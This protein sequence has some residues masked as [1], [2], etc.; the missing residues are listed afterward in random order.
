MRVLLAAAVATALTA[1]GPSVV[2]QPQR[3]PIDFP[4]TD[5]LLGSCLQLTPHTVA[6]T[7]EKVQLDLRIVLDGASRTEAVAAVAGM[8]RAYAPLGV[9]V[10]A[11]YDAV[12]LAGRD[13]GGLLAQAKQLY[14]GRRPADADVVYVLTDK[15]IVNGAA[16]GGQLAGL[17]DCIGGIR[18]AR[19]AF[20]VGELG[21]VSAPGVPQGTAKTMAHEVGHLLGAQHHYTGPEGRLDGDVTTPL[22]L[23]GPAVQLIAL[24]FSQLEA[25]MVRG[26][27]QKYA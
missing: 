3:S 18:F 14:G 25:L 10:V 27:A 22:S 9:S 16:T 7:A 19:R 4:D 1:T 21:S 2:A 11:T 8:R 13:A 17:A 20:A 23:M 5:A 24:R 6:L 15:D 26:H 12:R